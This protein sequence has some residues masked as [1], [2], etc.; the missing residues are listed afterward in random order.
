MAALR[1]RRGGPRGVRAEGPSPTHTTGRAGQHTHT[2]TQDATLNLGGGGE[3]CY[4]GDR[5][6][7][8]TTKKNKVMTYYP[9]N[10]VIFFIGKDTLSELCFVVLW[11]V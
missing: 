5:R 3:R 8:E 11:P 1:R 4:V 9:F 7:S 6:K 2:H 10:L